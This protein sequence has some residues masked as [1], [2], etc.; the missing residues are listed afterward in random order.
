ML[1]A[2]SLVGGRPPV[3]AAMLLLAA[4]VASMA[5]NGVSFAAVAEAAGSARAGT[6]LGLQ[7]TVVFVA[8]VAA[9][10]A[11]GVLVAVAGWP[12]GFAILALAPLAGAWT[13]GTLGR[14]A[15]PVTR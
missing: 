3:V 15:V 12:A 11:F 4:A 13:Y 10:P 9:P 8:V 7:N 1:V 5:G 6:A 14:G 2:L